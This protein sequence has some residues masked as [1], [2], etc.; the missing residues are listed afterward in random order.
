VSL[1]AFSLA[2]KTILVTGASSGIGRGVSVACAEQGATVIVS[3]RNQT[4][5]D[6]TLA[7][8][9]GAGHHAIAADLID[10]EQLK[11]LADECGPIDG[12]FF[13]AGIA[14]IAPFRMISEKHVRSVMAIDF[15]APVMLTQRLLQRKQ[16][17]VGG[18]I[19]FNTAIAVK[20]SPAGSAIYS[21]AKAALNAASRTLA[22]EVAKDRIR[23]TCLQCGYVQTELLEQLKQS[24]MDPAE[25]ASHTPLGIGTVEDAANAA[26]FLLSD[27]SRWISRTALT[28]D[29]GLSLRISH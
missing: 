1:D 26:I 20:N 12:L 5:L 23:V 14:A 9:S 25:L 7:S 3:G 8:L 28:M 17:R 19:V 11:R 2:G 29:G 24:G 4:R 6:A 27:A 18:S 10:P 22:L 21:A 16:V 13:S 15:E